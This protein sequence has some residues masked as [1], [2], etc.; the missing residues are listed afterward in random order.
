MVHFID[1]LEL[2]IQAQILPSIIQ[3][4]IQ[5]HRKAIGRLLPCAFNTII[6]T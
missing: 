4:T 1:N 5:D 6:K 2:Y 3:K